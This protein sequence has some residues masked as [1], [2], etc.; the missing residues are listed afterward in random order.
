MK[1][2][3]LRNLI[4]GCIFLF[5]KVHFGQ[6]PTL[7]AAESFTL[8]TAAGAFNVAGA[9]TFVTGDVGTHVGAFSGF[10]PGVLVGQIHVADAVTAAAATDVALA[11]GSLSIVT[12][13]QTISTTL[14]NGQMLLPGVY[15]TGAATTINGDLILD[16]QND[17]NAIFIF[18]FNGALATTVGSR[19]VMI[20]GASFCNLWWQ[21]NGQVDLGQNSEFKGNLLVNGAIHLL[22]GATLDGRGLSQAGAISL[23]NNTVTIGETPIVSTITAGGNPTTFC[24]GT[25]ITLSGN[26]GGTWSNGATTFSITVSTGGDYFVTNTT[27]CGSV[28]SNHILITVH[29]NPIC[30]IS[31]STSFCTG[32]STQLCVDS[33]AISYMWSTGESTNCI[34][35]D[36]AGTYSVTITDSNGC[37]SQ[38]SEEVV[39]NSVPVCNITGNS[40]FCIGGST[41]LCVQPGASSYLWSNGANTNCISIGQSGTFSVTITDFNGCSSQC[42]RMVTAHPL[43]VCMITGETSICSGSSTELCATLGAAAYIWN[44]GATTNCITVSQGGTYAVTITD[45][46]GCSSQCT[47]VVALF[48]NPV[49][50]ITGN[51]SFCPGGSTELCAPSGATSYEWN[52]GATTSCITVDQTGIYTVTITDSNGCT[53]SCSVDVTETNNPTCMIS[54]NPS[55]CFGGST[56]LCVPTGA[57]GY[58]WNNG[59]TTSCI[60][61]NTAGTYSVTVTYTNDCVSVCSIEVTET[62]NPTCVITGN[63]TICTGGSTELC[64]PTGASGYLWNNGATTSCI[65]V[66]TAGTYSVTVTYTNNCVSVCSIEVTETNNPTCVITGNPSICNGGSTELCVPSGTSGYLWNTGATTSCITV[67]T[68]GTYSVTVTYTNNCVSVCSIE[69]TE[70]NNP[71]CVIT[72][73]P[74]ICFGGSTVLCV[75][76]GASGYLWNTG[77]TTSCITVNTAGTYSVTVTYNNNCVSVCSVEVTETNNPSCVITGNPSIC[78]GGST[79][80]CVPTGASGYLWNTGATTSCITVNTAGTYSVTVT[81]VNN[82]VSVCSIEVTETN[83][84]T[85]QIISETSF[86]TGDSTLLY[87]LESGGHYLWN[88]GDTTRCLMVYAPGTYSVTVTYDNGCSVTCNK[89]ILETYIPDCIITGNVNICE[90][91]ATQL[92]V[93]SGYDFYLWSTGDTTNCIDVTCTG[94]YSVTVTNAEGCIVTCSKF[95]TI[96]HTSPDCIITGDHVICEGTTTLLCAPFECVSYLWSTG[97]TTRCI[98]VDSAGSYEVTVTYANGYGEIC[99][100]PVEVITEIPYFTISGNSRI[101]ESFT[102][103]LCVPFDNSTYVWNTGSVAKCIT[104]DMAGM[105]SVTVTEESGCISIGTKSVEVSTLIPDATITGKNSI[106]EGTSTKLCAPAGYA[107]YLWSKGVTTQCITI[108]TEGTHRVTVTDAGGCTNTGIKTVVKI[109][110][111]NCNITGNLYPK[112]GQST[113]LCASSGYSSYLWSTGERTACIKVFAAG[114]YS[115][116]ITNNLGCRNSCSVYVYN[117]IKTDINVSSYVHENNDQIN[118]V[119]YPNPFITTSTVEFH[120]ETSDA[121]V[122]IDLYNVTGTKISTLVDMDIKKGVLYTTELQADH[123]LPGIYIYRIVSGDHVLTKKIILMK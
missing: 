99:C 117:N 52:T 21:V 87:V 8:F 56:E 58:M 62:N 54:G 111:P 82:C 1:S 30:T 55:I 113:T 60:T 48:S 27:N 28:V 119:V 122:L 107:S 42:S 89:T 115:V 22:D 15:C 6:A 40:S 103:T 80:L 26:N 110:K 95:I 65:T 51:P 100:F 19:I 73:N 105:Y 86:C 2:I 77:A 14:G 85:C 5:P 34:S 106:C 47:H 92:C 72:G 66:N 121:H 39:E 64:V 12:C 46:N 61:V 76:T 74:S 98:L 43:P 114:T 63:P 69:V 9:S 88:T 45:A 24:M 36:A 104:V 68:A 3:F 78:F 93:V 37:T 112:N 41:Q 18:K 32:G 49:C 109:E 20:N 67:N 116:T 118:I 97:A 25:S 31:G 101:C 10:P 16:A 123:L 23:Q 57:S 59:A 44:N 96:G 33:G 53:S 83:N 91:G 4:I 13:G 75:P 120:S 102:T 35:V 81:Y 90:N 17:P 71:T 79:V 94:W 11:Y 70:T 38:C 108:N 29:P 84:P 50:N 7:G